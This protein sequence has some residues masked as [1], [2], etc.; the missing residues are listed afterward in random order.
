VDLGFAFWERTNPPLMALKTMLPPARYEQLRTEGAGLMRTM[1][2]ATDGTLV[3][4]SEYLSVI[5][6]KSRR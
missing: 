1:N 3:L 2:V 6:L 4:D 5:A